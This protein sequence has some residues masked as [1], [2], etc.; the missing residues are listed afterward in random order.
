MTIRLRPATEV[1]AAA[2]ATLLDA[3]GLCPLDETAQFG[4]NYVVAED[5]SGRIVAMAGVEV[6]G[7]HG[8]LRSVAVDSSARGI[9]L[10]LQVTAD[11]IEWSRRRGL[12][13]L[14]LLTVTAQGFFPRLGFSVAARDEAPPEIAAT[15]EWRVMCPASSVVMRR[16][17]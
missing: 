2:A 11:R 5:E 7:F 12:H 10:G 6:Y 8:L 15:R 1:D 17:L 3:A 16:S 9:G 14:W 13:E 4:P